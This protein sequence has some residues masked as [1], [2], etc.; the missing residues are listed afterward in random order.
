M[1]DQ[2][3]LYAGR[4]RTVVD[5]VIEYPHH[6]QDSRNRHGSSP[7]HARTVIALYSQLEQHRSCVSA[8]NTYA[9]TVIALY[10]LANRLEQHRPR[11]GTEEAVETGAGT[12]V[13]RL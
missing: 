3:K 8:S 4:R 6:F 1:L 10:S 9:R 7:C 5:N 12:E 13:T 2:Q 11:L